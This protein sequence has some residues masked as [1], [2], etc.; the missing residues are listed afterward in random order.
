MTLGF[1]F[2]TMNIMGGIITG[3]ALYAVRYRAYAVV[4]VLMTIMGLI[5]MIDIYI[6]TC[7]FILL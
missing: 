3:L 7:T 5:L 6:L 1:L 2:F 4:G